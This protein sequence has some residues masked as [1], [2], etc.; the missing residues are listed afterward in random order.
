MR[1]VAAIDAVERALD[2]RVA[3]V[4]VMLTVA[5]TV[6][7]DA[8]A[9]STETGAERSILTIAWRSVLALPARVYARYRIVVVPSTLTFSASAYG[10]T[11]SVP[12]TEYDQ[13]ATPERVSVAMRLTSTE[14]GD[15]PSGASSETVGA[16][17]GRRERDRWWAPRRYPPS[18]PTSTRGRGCPR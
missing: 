2:T 16:G 15:Q 5:A 4:D 8:G 14:S 13:E 10:R 7:H 3:V 18:R 17:R 1:G 12:S 6:V 9:S 11:D